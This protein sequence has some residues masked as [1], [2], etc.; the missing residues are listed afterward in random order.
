MNYTKSN[1]KL[2]DPEVVLGDSIC[3]KIKEAFYKDT[4]WA[5]VYKDVGERFTKF[6]KITISGFPG[7]DKMDFLR[8]LNK[9]TVQDIIDTFTDM[10]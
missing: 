3:E 7:T 10:E 1:G 6:K 2:A 4:P 9:F 8:A 5:D